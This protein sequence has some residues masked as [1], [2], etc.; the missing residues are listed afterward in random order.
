LSKLDNKQEW[1]LKIYCDTGQVQAAC[2]GDEPQLLEIENRI[3][4]SPPGKAFF[5]EKK[6]AE[7]LTRSTN[8]KIEEFNQQSFRSLKQLSVDTRINKVLPREVTERKDDMVL[9][10]AFLVNKQQANAFVGMAET[11]RLQGEDNGFLVDCTGP[12][13]PYNFCGL[14]RQEVKSA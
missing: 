13:P 2:G 5:L 10:S 4:S 1:G 9:N 6:R 8:V 7:L 11:L 3:K 12:W 14:S